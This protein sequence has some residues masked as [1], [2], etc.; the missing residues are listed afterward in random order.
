MMEVAH[1]IMQKK[2]EGMSLRDMLDGNDKAYD[3]QPNEFLY[4]T[5]KTVARDAFSQPEMLDKKKQLNDFSAKY[6]LG[7]MKMYE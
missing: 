3:E 5:F 2:Q 1:T 4:E 6:Y 7:C